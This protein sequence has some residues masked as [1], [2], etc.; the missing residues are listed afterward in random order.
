MDRAAERPDGG[1]VTTVY[2][3]VVDRFPDEDEPVIVQSFE[4]EAEARAWVAREN[5]GLTESR[6]FVQREPE[7][8]P[9]CEAC[10]GTGRYGFS[11]DDECPKCFGSGRI[12][13]RDA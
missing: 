8:D 7:E 11:D 10:A 9:E 13:T 2:W 12:V 3:H 5:D 1:G 6:Y 4:S